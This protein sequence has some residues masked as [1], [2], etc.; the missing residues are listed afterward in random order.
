MQVDLKMCGTVDNPCSLI[1]CASKSTFTEVML[2]SSILLSLDKALHSFGKVEKI[3]MCETCSKSVR[4]VKAVIQ[5]VRAQVMC[6]Y[7]VIS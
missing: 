1:K 3:V 6:T 4:I 2:Q 7:R 5:V